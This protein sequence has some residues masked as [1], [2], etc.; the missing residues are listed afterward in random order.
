MSKAGK[1]MRDGVWAILISTITAAALYWT[2][3]SDN[4]E[5]MLYDTGVHYA[6]RTPS[7]QIAILAIDDKSIDVIGRWPWSRQVIAN[8]IDKLNAEKP[9]SII[10]TSFYFEPQT[11]AGLGY[12]S[13]ALS[14]IPPPSA[15]VVASQTAMGLP[16]EDPKFASVRI[17]LQSAE[18]DLNVDRK[19]AE[20]L[21]KAGNVSLPMLPNLALTGS[22]QGR[23]DPLPPF[24]STSRIGLVM[25]PSDTSTLNVPSVSRWQTP[26][27]SL[28]KYAN[29]IGFLTVDTNSVVRQELLYLQAGDD[30]YP[31]LSLLAATQAL[32]LKPADIQLKLGGTVGVGFPQAPRAL[33]D[34]FSTMQQP[35]PLLRLIPSPM[36]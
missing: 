13:K 11:D 15:E 26:L 20:S 33:G 36:F 23:S 12:I 21:K 25:T 8:L 1:S 28:G 24:L 27:E 30:F 14:L 10:N 16:A 19:L 17:L 18:K 4:L 6:E 35:A 9:K 22:T 29:G 34:P 32:N 2:G 5:G 3:L 7:D 31:S